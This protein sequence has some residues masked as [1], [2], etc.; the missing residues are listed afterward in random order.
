MVNEIN[1]NEV[2]KTGTTTIGVVCKDG[3]VLA[4]DKRTT[5]GHMIVNGKTE[6]I[7][8]VNEDIALTTAGNVSDSQLL[9]KLLK[10]EIKLKE[11]RTNRRP[12]VKEVANL[13]AGMIYNN[14]RRMSTIPGISHFVMGGRDAK[15]YWLYDLFADGSLTKIEDYVSSGSGS[16]FALGVLETMFKEDMTVEETI[17]IVIKAV[18]A[19][20]QRDSAS[21]NGIDVFTV[22]EKGV[23]KAVQ[24]MLDTRLKS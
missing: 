6:K 23:Q 3:I 14:I 2:L 8:Q 12:G 20:L 5:A 18:N 10:A 7:I 21:G 1:K 17:P 22:T 16:T 9:V 24:Q 19:A 15:G 4:A 13:C 11:M